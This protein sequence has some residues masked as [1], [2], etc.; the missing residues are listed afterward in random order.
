LSFD[1]LPLDILSVIAKV[2]LGGDVESLR[3]GVLW[4]GNPRVGDGN[5]RGVWTGKNEMST[6][7]TCPESIEKIVAPPILMNDCCTIAMACR[8][9]NAVCVGGGVVGDC[10]ADDDDG[11]DK[12]RKINGRKRPTRMRP[13]VCPRTVRLADKINYEILHHKKTRALCR[14]KRM[15][16]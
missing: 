14:W 10:W 7:Q 13:P 8:C 2:A 6:L 15:P 11:N 12:P 4:N 3:N 1:S 5:V 16:R 9:P